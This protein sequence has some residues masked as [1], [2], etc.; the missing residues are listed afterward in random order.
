MSFERGFISIGVVFCSFSIHFFIV[1]LIFVIFD[2]EVILL[3]GCLSSVNVF[4]F[5]FVFLLVVGG[6]YLEWY[7]GK[8][9]WLI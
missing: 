2:I 3:V 4:V 8:L 7:L 1:L 6:V 9:S 5:F